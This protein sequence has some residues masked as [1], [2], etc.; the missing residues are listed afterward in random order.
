MK[1]KITVEQSKSISPIWLVIIEN[2]GTKLKVEIPFGSDQE[3]EERANGLRA[4]L[5]LVLND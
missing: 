1:F 2:I 3:S 4:R 5:E